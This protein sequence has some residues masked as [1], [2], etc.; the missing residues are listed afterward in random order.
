MR[1]PYACPNCEYNSTRHWNVKLHINKKHGGFGEP[2][3]PYGRRELTFNERQGSPNS[4]NRAIQNTINEFPQ[5]GEFGNFDRN[6]EREMQLAK[7]LK[8]IVPQFLEFERLIRLHIPSEDIWTDIA[9]TILPAIRSSD[10]VSYMN[11]A[12]SFYKNRYSID[13]MLF[14]ISKYMNLNVFQVKSA[15]K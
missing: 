15:L 4:N 12:I 13:C 11:E 5:L 1:I 2:A 9:T 14:C 6:D 10:P 8:T 3:R 7:K